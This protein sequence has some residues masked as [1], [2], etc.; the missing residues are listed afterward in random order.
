MK[1]IF[2]IVLSFMLLACSS[3]M[4]TYPDA[5]PL[6]KVQTSLSVKRLWIKQTDFLSRRHHAQLPPLVQDDALYYAN[7]N[8]EVGVLDA[9]RGSRLWKVSTHE[10]LTAGPGVGNGLIIVGTR[11][12]EVIALAESNGSELWRSR[13][14]SEMLASP[15]IDAQQIILQTIE[16]KII[17]LD[18]TNGKQVWSYSHSTPALS[19]RGTSTPLLHGERVLAGFAD[20]KLVALDRNSGKLLWQ[21]AVAVPRGRTDLERLVDIDGLFAVDQQTVFV[22][23][24]QGNLAAISVRNGTT[25][26][27]RE[28]SSYAGLVES[29]NRIIIT[30]ADGQVWAL[31]KRTG[32]TLWRQDQ[33]KLREPSV[34][35]VVGNALAVGDFDGY[36]HWLSLEDGAIVARQSMEQLWRKANALRPDDDSRKLR[37]RSISVAPLATGK[38][39][40][41]RDNLGALAAFQLSD[42]ITD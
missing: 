19:I 2:I 37:W 33:L 3:S 36:I 40:Y 26:W 18:A 16:G 35:A 11:K 30:D 39:L 14:S 10:T 22:S 8:G 15:R 41:V 20:G 25:L 23:S 7:I 29:G 1:Q 4:K 38:R 5:T 27:S 21:T 13:I 42:P 31:D 9:A 34:P 24:Y 17:A 32:G 12:A 6:E 28:I